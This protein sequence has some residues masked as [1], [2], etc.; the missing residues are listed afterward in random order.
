[1]TTGFAKVL[2]SHPGRQHSHQA[3]LAL[4]RAGRLAG[5]WAGVPSRPGQQRGIAG[6]MARHAHRYAPV[7][8]P[9]ERARWL[10]VAVVLRRLGRTL[11][12]RKEQVIDFLA[13]RAFDRQVAKQL[14]RAG[15]RA[16]LACEIS[17]LDTFR[18]AKR[19]GMVTILDAPSFHY[20]VQDRVTPVAEW[21]WL[22]ERIVDV[23]R[24]EIALADHVITVSELARAGYVDGGV[25]DARVHA[26][27][28]GA[29]TRLF[30][31]GGT[32]DR[33]LSAPCTFVFAGATIHRKGLDVLLEAFA[34]LRRRYPRKARLV[35]VGP[36]SDS[37]AIIREVLAR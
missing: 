37:H 18:A 26:V 30:S 5:Y 7:D 31:P 25:S 1:M 34:E 23:K 21:L 27:A 36:R 33:E 28:V 35:V 3:A 22:H 12:I 2:V 4:E 10:P 24:A 20:A 15:A 13:C 11:P 16:V 6:W 9:E 32:G 8:L 14:G 17:A 29:D 19:V